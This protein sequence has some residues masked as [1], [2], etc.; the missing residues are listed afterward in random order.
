MKIYINRIPVHG[1]WGG[2]NKTVTQLVD[3]LIRS[4]HTVVF[5]LKDSNIDVLFCFDPRP[6]KF[7]EGY[8]DIL[9]YKLKFGAKIIQR[10]GDAGTH[11]KPELT[12]LVKQTTKISDHIIFPSQ[13][14]KEHIGFL[15]ENYNII[16]NRPLPSFHSY[17]QN[18]G[19]KKKVNI[20]THHWSDNPRKGFSTY[21]QFDEHCSNNDKFSFTYIGRIPKGLRF[22][23]SSYIEPQDK[24]FLIKALPQYDIYLTASEEEAGANH[25]LEAMAAGLPVLYRDNGGS[26]N[27][28]CKNYG[29]PYHN[30]EELIENLSILVANYDKI[31]QNVLKFDDIIDQTIDEYYKTICNI[32][33]T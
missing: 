22:K 27:E 6:N 3:K 10:V 24:E 1:P 17:K 20:V 5:D 18:K 31:K 13:W 21:K 23:S 8:K 30:I 19:L 9:N 2:G 33:S 16:P 25:V 12:S 32:K 14:V 28:Y 4:G 11:G 7:G 15:K 26:I 29:M